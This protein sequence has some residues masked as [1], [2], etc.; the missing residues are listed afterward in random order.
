MIYK[1][2]ARRTS[3]KFSPTTLMTSV[4]CNIRN[5]I[6]KRQSTR[7]QHGESDAS[8]A[9]HTQ[10]HSVALGKHTYTDARKSRSHAKSLVCTK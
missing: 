6:Y 9:K 10:T 5:A 7:G 3:Q 4:K 8:K 2:N 1:Q